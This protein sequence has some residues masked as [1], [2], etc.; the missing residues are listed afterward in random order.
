[1]LLVFENGVALVTD[2]NCQLIKM[3]NIKNV[4]RIKTVVWNHNWPNIATIVFEKD[5]E[6]IDVFKCQTIRVIE[7]VLHFD[8]RYYDQFIV[9]DQDFFINLYQVD[10]DKP[11]LQLKAELETSLIEFNQSKTLLASFSSLLNNI[12]V[13]TLLNEQYVFEITDDSKILNFCWCSSCTLSIYYYYYY[14][15]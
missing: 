1:M 13:W 8:W 11:L 12:K 5:M 4:N 10:Q 9:M 3:F 6:I 14:L 7:N 2:M 15:L